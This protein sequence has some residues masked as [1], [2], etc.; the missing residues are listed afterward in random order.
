MGIDSKKPSECGKI[1][2]PPQTQSINVYHMYVSI[3]N[4]TRGQK[5]LFNL[6]SSP[7]GCE[8]FSTL[9]GITNRGHGQP[10]KSQGEAKLNLYHNNFA[11]C[12]YMT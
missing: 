7:V 8:D 12:S 1:V 10:Q 2:Y 11:G 4:M 5:Y 6:G 9:G 3:Q